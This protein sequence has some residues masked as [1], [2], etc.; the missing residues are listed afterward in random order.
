MTTSTRTPLASLLRRRRPLVGVIMKMNSPASIELTGYLGFDLVVIDT[1]HGVGGGSDLDHHLRAAD[2][3]AVPAIVRVSTLNRSEIQY[4][5]DGG[6][7]GV[8]V[9]QVDS[10][11]AARQAVRLAH[12]PPFGDRGLATSTRAGHHGTVVTATHLEAARHGTVIVVQIESGV[13]VANADAILGVD[14][15]SAV[16]IG[17]SDLSLD[18]G[19]WGD[20]DHPAV[21]DAITTVVKAA[22]RASVPLMV[23]ADQES[24]GQRWTERGA[25][26]L[27][28][29][30]LTVLTR[31]LR[32][33]QDSHRRTA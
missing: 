28:I 32:D 4:A 26:V 14:G 31:G 27:L 22:D 23:I 13:G 21:A 30:L 7:A 15:I 19:H 29:N 17:L 10:A 5:L 12:Y 3:A 1:E 9:P 33:L 11:D 2:A 8:V 6:A 16:W 18:L 24:D 25:K 20:Y